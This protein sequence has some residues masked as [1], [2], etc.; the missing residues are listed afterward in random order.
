MAWIRVIEPDEATGHLARIYKAAQ[1]RAGRVFHVLSIQS[2]WPRVLQ[3]ST[4]FY[5]QMMQGPGPLERRRREMIAT[6]VSRANAC[7]Y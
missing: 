4:Q 6:T 3:S 1:K 5:T 2:L 7:A